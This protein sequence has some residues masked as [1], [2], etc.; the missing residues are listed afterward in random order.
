MF[1]AMLFLLN[2]NHH[3]YLNNKFSKYNLNV[4]QGLILL[5]LSECE[6]ISQKELGDYLNLSKG[7]IAKYL[8]DLEENNFIKRNRLE[9]NKRKYKLILE[10]KSINLIPELKNISKDWEQK[11][12]LKDLNP[13]FLKDFEKLLK[14]STKLL[15]GE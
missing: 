7:S 4:I 15:E 11:T 13:D 14:Q 9:N 2:K 3:T 5:K 1:G 10:D 12:G 8:A 6:E